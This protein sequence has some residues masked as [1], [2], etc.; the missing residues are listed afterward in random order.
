MTGSANVGENSCPYAVATSELQGEETH[1]HEPV[2]DPDRAPLQHPG[3]AERLRQHGAPAGS[4]MVRA[5]DGRAAQADHSDHR[6]D[7]EHGEDHRH[8]RDRQRDDD[9]DNLHEFSCTYAGRLD[10][11]RSHQD[12][13]ASRTRGRSRE[14][15]EPT[16]QAGPGHVTGLPQSV[17]HVVLDRALGQEQLFRDGRLGLLRRRPGAGWRRP[18]PFERAHRLATVAAARR[19]GLGVRPDV[20]G[21]AVLTGGRPPAAFPR[22]PEP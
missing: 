11:S 16:G 4:R 19:R 8:R 9:R 12:S 15:G 21:E 10:P 3:V 5:A 7:G 18:R 1:E 2:H 20:A 13:P 14:G 17:A 6:A 22:A